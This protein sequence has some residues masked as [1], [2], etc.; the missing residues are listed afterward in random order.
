MGAAF[1]SLVEAQEVYHDLSAKGQRVT[2]DGFSARW[3]PDGSKLAF[4][5][6][7]H[8]SSG[9]AVFD[10]ATKET[11]L[12][13]VPGKLP[14]WSPDGQYLAFVRDREFLPIAELVAAPRKDQPYAHT[15]EEVWLMKSDGTEPRRVARGGWPSWSRDSTHIYYQS[16]AD[17]I[18]YSIPIV[19]TNVEPKQVMVC[20]GFCPSVSPD[21]KYVAYTEVSG[22]LKVQDL[23]SRALVAAWSLP[24]PAGMWTGPVWAPGGDELYL[25]GSGGLD[26]RTGLWIYRLGGG[27]PVTTL[28]G[29]I[30]AG[31]WTLDR[32]KL[33]FELGT[34]GFE[35]W[36]ADLDPRA[37]S[38]AA[39]GPARSLREHFRDLIAFYTRR[40]DAD[41]A[42]AT[43]YIRRAELYQQLQEE[44][45][46]R[47]DMRRHVATLKQ[48]FSSSVRLGGPWAFMRVVKGP[49]GYQLVVF[50]ERQEDGMQVLR[51]AFGQ[52]GRCEMKMLEI[53]MVATS[54]FG[55]CLLS[56]LDAP[57]H[58]PISPLAVP[59]IWGP[60]SIPQVTTP[61]RAYRLTVWSSTSRA[62]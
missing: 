9:V 22:F 2:S 32:T 49:L 56:G 46:V 35:I 58:M 45:S 23:A 41:P 20:P 62:W 16:P 8:G 29:S 1:L 61:D 3:S 31:A 15:D 54:L 24:L 21:E 55:L 28:R 4:T 51:I 5:L 53:P 48:G 42:E 44:A 57:P 38:T 18:V 34:P 27:E 12:L 13:I 36:T 10:I 39:L 52:K 37:S 33:V 60:Q 6:G 30:M 7:V 43:S 25:G 26:G 50:L 47:A 14:R 59:R 11:D 17:R 19:G 40:I